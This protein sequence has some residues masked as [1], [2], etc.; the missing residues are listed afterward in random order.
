MY[1]RLVTD[2]GHHLAARCKIAA[3][4]ESD[5]PLGQRTQPL[6]LRLGGGDLAVFE[7]GRGEVGQHQPLMRRTTA[8]TGTLGWRRH[9]VLLVAFLAD[10]L[11]NP[12]L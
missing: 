9:C 1:H 11:S 4:G 2:D 8:E 3:L 6:G 5:E 10:G 12:P 7:K